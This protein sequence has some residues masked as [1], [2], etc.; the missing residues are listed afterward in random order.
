[1]HYVLYSS[2]QLC[3]LWPVY[4]STNTHILYTHLDNR[5][6]LKTA[7]NTCISMYCHGMALGNNPGPVTGSGTL[8]DSPMP[9]TCANKKLAL[10]RGLRFQ[11]K[12]KGDH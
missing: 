9:L 5:E 1:M 10:S 3:L 4:H 11:G 6:T 2:Y 8:T 7:H 12:S